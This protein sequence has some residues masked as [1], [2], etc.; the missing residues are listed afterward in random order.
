MTL[1]LVAWLA[2][3]VLA[4]DK[5]TVPDLEPILLPFDLDRDG[6]ISAEELA[7]AL[8]HFDL[9]GDGKVSQAELA[10]PGKREFGRFDLDGNGLLDADE[11]LRTTVLLQAFPQPKVSLPNPE[12]PPPP[13]PHP[14]G[15]APTTEKT[16]LGKMLFW[17]QQLSSNNT[18]ACGSCHLPEAG[19]ADLRP[20]PHPGHDGKWNTADDVVGS[21]GIVALTK[22]DK[23]RDVPPFGLRVQTTRRSAQ[24]FFGALH[25]RELF[26]DGRAGDKLVDPLSQ[27]VVLASGAALES[28][29]LVP[30]LRSDE[31]SRPGRTWNDVTQK[32]AAIRPLARASA[33]TPDITA[34][35]A[36]HPTYPALFEHAFGDAAITPVRIAMTIASYERTLLP[37]KTP[38]D[39]YIRGDK[40]ALTEEQQAGWRVFRQSNCAVCHAPPLFTDNTF[41]NI[42]LRPPDED[43]GRAEVTQTKSK[44]SLSYSGNPRP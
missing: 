26:W 33:L 7:V 31:M 44:E 3:I 12:G 29:T 43:L 2:A 42:G 32:L 8:R 13:V 34:A 10:G 36:A 21:P 30:I 14:P 5:P 24:S 38:F 23:P 6:T 15:N 9:D 1:S 39:A 37:D 4:G 27:R 22:D 11:L 17:D 20:G 40:K 18:V 16:V 25:A 28:Q 41:R 19:G 35:L